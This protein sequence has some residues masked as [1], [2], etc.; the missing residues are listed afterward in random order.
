[1][2]EAPPDRVEALALSLTDDPVLRKMLDEERVEGEQLDRALLG[3]LGGY[4]RPRWRLGLSSFLMALLESALNAAPAWLIGLAMDRVLGSAARSPG[5]L[6]RG[7]DALGASFA[8]RFGAGAQ[9]LGA[10][11]VFFGLLTA[12]VWVLTWAVAVGTTWLMQRLGQEVVHALRV[13]IF[14]HITGMDQGFFHKNPVGRLVNRTVFDVQALS[15]LFSDAFAQ[16]LRDG[17]SVLTLVVVML[18]LDAPLALVLIVSLPLLVAVALIYR[19][20]ARPALRTNSAVQSRMNAW[21]AE[22]ISGMRE[23]QLYRREER[24]RAEYHA[25]T[26]AHQASI[27]H[28]ILAWA[29]LR[30]GMMVISAL[31][32]AAVLG[33]GY[34]RVTEGLITVGVL[35][36]FLQYTVNFWRPVRNLS[37]KF[38]LIQEA[39]TSAERIMDVLDTQPQITDRPDADPSLRVARGEIRLEGVRFTYPGTTQEVLKGIDVEVAQGQVLA[40]VGDTG[41]GKSTIAHLLSRFYEASGGRVLVDGRDVREYKLQHLREG[42]ALVPQDVVIFAGTI[43]ENITLGAPIDEARIWACVRA[44]RADALVERL[45]GLDH[46]LTEGGRTLSNGERQLLSFARALAQAPPILLLD[47]ATANVDTQ[48]EL[49]IQEAL[50]ALTRGRTCVII[51][52]RLSTIRDADQILLLQNGEVVE[53][54]RHDELMRLDGDYARLVRLH[55]GQPGVHP[56]P[57]SPHL[58]GEG[59][60]GE[61]A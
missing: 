53:R 14:S 32:T 18:W 48:T 16:G 40:L 6:E 41:A 11:V 44:V 61:D 12:L 52:H 35:L 23:N 9:D 8:A 57:S 50:Q 37:E 29:V 21:L 30:P 34:W 56:L 19:R 15:G 3:R 13:Q 46:A 10:V 2:S 20:M 39:L 4:L 36:A 54:G 28:V 60:G 5:A 38:N 33:L 31:A 43:R 17:L 22:N 47:E 45:G 7:L 25:L 26:R 55:M 42:I 51:A 49:R 27:R 59:V 58:S 24:R 1:V